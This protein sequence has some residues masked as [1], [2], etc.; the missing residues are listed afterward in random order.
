MNQL[1]A[2]EASYLEKLFRGQ[3]SRVK[4][5]Q[6][7]GCPFWRAKQITMVVSLIAIPDVSRRKFDI[8]LIPMATGASAACTM[9]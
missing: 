7:G 8:V 4:F 2:R 3:A 6:S 5:S 1:V 9:S